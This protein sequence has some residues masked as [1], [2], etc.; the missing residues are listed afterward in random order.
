MYLMLGFERHLKMKLKKNSQ[1]FY[2]QKFQKTS[3]SLI[4]I[5]KIKVRRDFEIRV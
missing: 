5:V 3:D 1:V 4:S 2:F